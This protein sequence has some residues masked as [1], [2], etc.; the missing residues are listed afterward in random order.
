MPDP[1]SLRL[2]HAHFAD[3]DRIAQLIHRSTNAWYREHFGHEVFTCSPSE[4]R[5]FIDVYD[6]LDP[7]RCL[8]I[9]DPST[10][11]LAGSCFVHPRATH[12]SLGILNVDP[13]YFGRGV[14]GSLVRAVTD[15]ADDLRLPTRLVS[16]AMN[17]DSYSL[18]T[19]AG[20]VP[21]AFFQDV[22]IQAP[23]D[24]P[25][26]DDGLARSARERV[27]PATLRDVPALVA[28]EQKR[29]GITRTDDL[30]YFIANAHGYWHTL[31]VE[32]EQGE[33]AGYVVS[34]AQPA[35]R[36]IGPGV[37]VDQSAMIALIAAQLGY[38]AGQT[39]L[40]VAPADQSGLI[41]QLYRWGGRNC[42]THVAQ[43]RPVPGTNASP[44]VAGVFLPTFLPESA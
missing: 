34:I 14:A 25:A 10:G 5:L 16:S 24:E 23:A 35:C 33:L 13:N 7:G 20:F 3:A 36:I 1:S 15:L 18:Y 22:L 6:A 37:A 12:V 39:M 40:V 42:E 44:R 28:L 4:I 43:C 2:R 29:L 38:R 9:E 8:V 30:A 17:L 41:R 31:V 11:E 21:Y 27:R 19:R 26:I 32:D